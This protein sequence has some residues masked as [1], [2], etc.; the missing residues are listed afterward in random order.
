VATG[1]IV[2]PD[3]RSANVIDN[4]VLTARAAHDSGVRQVWLPQNF[5]YDALALAALVSLA[6]PVDRAGSVAAG[7][8]WAF[9][10]ATHCESAGEHYRRR[11]DHRDRH[12][13]ATRQP[14]FCNRLS[15]N[16]YR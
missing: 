6:V 11:R 3:R 9:A 5:D 7:W 2:S 4:V 1:V 16:R 12:S 15:G 14:S 8:I 13:A 10:A